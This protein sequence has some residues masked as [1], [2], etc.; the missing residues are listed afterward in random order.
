MNEARDKLGD[1]AAHSRIT[2][3][4]EL[5]RKKAVVAAALERAQAKRARPAG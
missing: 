1:I 5:E 4:Q 2:D 3:P